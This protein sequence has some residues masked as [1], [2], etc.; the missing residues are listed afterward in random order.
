MRGTMKKLLAAILLLAAANAAAELG[1]YNA[2]R[3]G[4]AISTL[5]DFGDVCAANELVVRN[6]S[7]TANVC[8]VNAS[9]GASTAASYITQ[10]AEGGLSN[11][12]ALGGLATGLLINESQ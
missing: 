4:G 7:D 5:A 1:M 8:A 9:G 6:G 2:R 11:E 10:T 3:G 12:V